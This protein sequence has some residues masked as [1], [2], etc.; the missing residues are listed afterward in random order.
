M[1]LKDGSKRSLL[2]LSLAILLVVVMVALA[3]IL[4]LEEQQQIAEQNKLQESMLAELDARVGDYDETKIV[5]NNTSHSRAQSLAEAI[6]AKLRITKDG[7]FATLTLTDGRTIRD[8]VSNEDNKALLE[9][10]GIDYKASVSDLEESE[11][12]F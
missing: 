11:E 4:I 3:G 9:S 10:F 2:T 7:S 12:E 5:L 8:I 1:Q 6:G